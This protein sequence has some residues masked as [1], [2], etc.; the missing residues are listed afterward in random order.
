MFRALSAHLQEVSGKLEF[1]IG[2]QSWQTL[3]AFKLTI[4]G[5]CIMNLLYVNYQLDALIIIYS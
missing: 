1:S 3:E 4:F 5:P 2:R